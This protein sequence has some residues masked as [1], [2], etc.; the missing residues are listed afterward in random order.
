MDNSVDFS[1]IILDSELRFFLT[2]NRRENIIEIQA[3]LMCICYQPVQILIFNSPK[4]GSS[5]LFRLPL[6]AFYREAIFHAR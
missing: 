4:A 1:G 6:N 2:N 5:V 3:A